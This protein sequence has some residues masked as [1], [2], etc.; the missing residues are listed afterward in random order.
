MERTDNSMG[1]VVSY[2]NKFVDNIFTGKSVCCDH[3]HD[4]MKTN[5]E[6]VKTF[7]MHAILPIIKSSFIILWGHFKN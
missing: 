2:E 3:L 1:F 5:A 6:N 7:I 4:L